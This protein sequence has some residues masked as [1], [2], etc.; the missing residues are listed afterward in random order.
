MHSR[1]FTAVVQARDATN[2]N[3]IQEVYGFS[4]MV[5]PEVEFK[6]SLRKQRGQ[7][8]DMAVLKT[9]EFVSHAKIKGSGLEGK[10]ETLAML[11]LDFDYNGDI[12][13]LDKAYFGDDL[14]KDKWEATFGPEAIGERVAAI[15]VDHHGNEF[16]AVI[17]RE[18]F[19]LTVREEP[20]AVA[21][22]PRQ[23]CRPKRKN[24][25]G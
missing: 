21:D 9:T 10:F 15:W 19:G 25:K 13:D 11:M 23:G 3:D 24:R 7:M 16:K 14:E 18:A 5:A 6:A 4:F 22:R 17:P 12:F 1:D 2:V 8:F 20:V